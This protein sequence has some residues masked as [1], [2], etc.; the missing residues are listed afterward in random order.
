MP[1][2]PVALSAGLSIL[3]ASR[4]SDD[5]Q[6]ALRAQEQ[7]SQR[8]LDY[9]RESRDIGLSQAQPFYESSVDALNR[10]RSMMG[11]EGSVSAPEITQRYDFANSDVLKNIKKNWHIIRDAGNY[12]AIN[13]D[14]LGLPEGPGTGPEADAFIEDL[15]TNWN[16]IRDAKDYNAIDWDYL[17]LPYGPGSNFVPSQSGATS[18]PA[19][20]GGKTLLPGQTGGATPTGIPPKG[21]AGGWIDSTT[22]A[23]VPTNTS[24]FGGIS[25]DPSYQFRLDEGMRALEGSAFARGGGMSGGFARKAMRYA[26][27]YAS[28]EYTNIYNRLANMAGYAQ[29]MP[30]GAAISQGYGVNAANSARNRGEARA[31]GYTAQGNAWQNAMDQLA[32]IDWGSIVT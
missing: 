27:D 15:R 23:P 7:A 13:W 4:A 16:V 22:G 17:G 20:V 9:L 21:S 19:G 5:A 3:G 8:E 1:A 18:L 12:D 2:W 24:R 31:S 11:F 29:V 28:T 26:Q 30:A 10:M 32:R 6:R 25:D 14:Y